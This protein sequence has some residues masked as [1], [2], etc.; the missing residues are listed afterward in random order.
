M[1]D[2][3]FLFNEEGNVATGREVV[4]VPEDYWYTMKK[5][6]IA[7]IAGYR[8]YYTDGTPDPSNDEV[9]ESCYIEVYGDV[10][11]TQVRLCNLYEFD[12]IEGVKKLYDGNEV[13]IIG[14]YEDA[15]GCEY[16]AF[17]F[18]DELRFEETCFLDE[19]RR[20]SE[21][22]EDEL[23]KFYERCTHGSM[24]LSDY[25]NNLGIEINEASAYADAWLEDVETGCYKD[26][27]EDYCQW[28]SN[29]YA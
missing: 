6:V 2:F 17:M 7:N 1:R 4:V 23:K 15:D 9:D 28:V 24:L 13:E 12:R 16:Y 20:I 19:R 22:N 27:F 3:D 21:L 18:N 25:H 11:D 14:S 26:T 29:L 5:K 10:D 8:P